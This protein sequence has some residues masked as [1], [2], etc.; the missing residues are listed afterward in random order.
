[1]IH[2]TSALAERGHAVCVVGGVQAARDLGRVRWLPAGEAAAADVRVAVNDARLLAGQGGLPVVWFHNEVG[3]WR[4]VRKR[5]LAALCRYRPVAVFIGTEQA[6]RASRMLPFRRRVVIPY[7]LPPAVLAA[8]PG[9]AM[10]GPCAVFTSQAYR[11]LREVIAMW[12]AHVSPLVPGARLVAY[13]GDAELAPYAAL[14]A[15]DA[16]IAI[17][18]R[19]GNAAMLDVLRDARLLLAP[20]HV[21][22]TFCL[23]AAEAVAMG[24]PVVTLGVGSLKE[25]VVDGVT[26]FLCSD[27]RQMAAR[28]R[29]ALTDDDIWKR[30]RANG[31]A[32]RSGSDWAVAAEAWEACADDIIAQR[33]GAR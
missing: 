16:S 22:E 1:M 14:A 23:A 25:R 27:W 20:G 12:R 13:V 15:G 17:R 18:Q 5:R 10:P 30:M 2:L 9:A 32:S 3:A 29:E 7:G 24:V 6:R 11:G 4:E 33:T 21:S 19:V 26:G 8:A 28:V 31:L